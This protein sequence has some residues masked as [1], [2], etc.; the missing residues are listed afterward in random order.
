MRGAGEAKGVRG[1]EEQA[2]GE[3]GGEGNNQPSPSLCLFVVGRV[4]HLS[5]SDCRAYWGGIIHRI[6]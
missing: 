1:E 3:L 5:R 4:D 6:L 2:A